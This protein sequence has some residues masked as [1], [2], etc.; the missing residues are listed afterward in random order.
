MLFQF[1]EAQQ[2]LCRCLSI[3]IFCSPSFHLSAF[4]KLHV[5]FLYFL[6]F[7]V[8]LG[9]CN[10]STLTPPRLYHRLV[11]GDW[12]NCPNLMEL[13]SK[14]DKTVHCKLFYWWLLYL[15][16]IPQRH[17]WCE[18]IRSSIKTWFANG[19]RFKKI[20]CQLIYWIFQTAVGKMSALLKKWL[21]EKI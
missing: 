4:E 10:L 15:M 11:G 5:Q 19:F 7:K 14:F 12:T 16:H 3:K 18:R 9:N 17:F 13:S 21:K 8:E 20:K 1:G 6:I 2:R